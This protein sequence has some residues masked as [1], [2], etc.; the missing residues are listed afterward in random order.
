MTAMATKNVEI[1]AVLAYVAALSSLYVA[2]YYLTVPYSRTL[3]T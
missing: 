3:Y 1:V 2:C